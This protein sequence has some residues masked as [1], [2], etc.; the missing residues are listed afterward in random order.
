M[1]ENTG[2]KNKNIVIKLAIWT[3]ILVAGFVVF[4]ANYI[5]TD[6]DYKDLY[7]YDALATVK[8]SSMLPSET[9][10]PNVTK[11]PEIIAVPSESLTPDI[12][13][14]ILPDIIPDSSK[15]P[16]KTIEPQVTKEPISTQTISPVITPSTVT[17]QPDITTNIKSSMRESTEKDV[18]NSFSINTKLNATYENVSYYFYGKKCDEVFVFYKEKGRDY[19]KLADTPVYSKNDKVYK[20]SICYLD[21]GKEYDVKIEFYND[22]SLVARQKDKVTTKN[23]NVKIAKTIKLSDC[24]EKD[25]VYGV[26]LK[27]IKGS[28][29]GYIRIIGDIDIVSEGDGERYIFENEVSA[30]KVRT[31]SVNN[32]DYALLMHS[33]EYV[34]LEGF[35]VKGGK[36]A[37]VTIYGESNNIILR[38][39]DISKYGPDVS[40]YGENGVP[41]DEEGNIVI[42]K[43]GLKLINCYDILF[44]KSKIHSPKADASNWNSKYDSSTHPQGNSGID[45]MRING[46][47]V[48]RNNEIM[49]SKDAYLM[50]CIEGWMNESVEGGIY[51]DG[52][53]Y[54]NIFKYANDDA[55]ELDGGQ[56]NI[57]VYDNYFS[58]C[59]CGVSVSPNYKGPS[60]IFRNTFTSMMDSEGKTSQCIKTVWNGEVKDGG[61]TFI[62]HNT[63]CTKG[64]V[65]A[66][67]R[68]YSFASHIVTAN[69]IMYVYGTDFCINNYV[70]SK[71]H[72]YN[73]DLVYNSNS[74]KFTMRNEGMYELEGIFKNPQFTNAKKGDFT[75]KSTSPAIDKGVMIN[76]F[77]DGYKGTAPDLGRYESK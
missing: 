31:Q 62:Y 18:K 8:P 45:L 66:L 4:M 72:S 56:E 28:K 22:H 37:A 5:T 40:Y 43:Y 58:D 17:Q 53:I 76:N 50:D 15:P 55:I 64:A 59:L 26:Y 57:R 20:G 42:R 32:L 75:L 7:I 49:G 11:T 14:D 70:N 60:Y 44:E 74:H 36:E 39:F 21:E 73:H 10:L 47:I 63:F 68:E 61:Y 65:L 19:W 54:G 1:A 41:Y 48:I 24:I 35:N 6:N 30:D 3:L 71:L 52:D 12:N 29:N 23:S 2:N 51:A 25:S 9:K 16:V 13:P 69:N 38:D 34:I 67:F 27:G 33:C 77:S 46:G